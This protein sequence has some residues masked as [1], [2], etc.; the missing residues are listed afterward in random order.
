MRLIDVDELE[1]KQV[2]PN[3]FVSEDYAYGCNYIINRVKSAPTIDAAPVVHAK[4]RYKAAY[5][6]HAHVTNIIYCT[7][8]GKG[9][10]RIEGENFNFCPN[11]G[12]RMDGEA[13]DSGK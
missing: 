7:A 6:A 4:W 2:K 13:H 11:C 1:L 12:A 5:A 3:I 9:F 10:H 8:C